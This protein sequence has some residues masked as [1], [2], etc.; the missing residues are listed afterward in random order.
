MGVPRVFFCRVAWNV[1]LCVREELA[2]L[3]GL[4]RFVME[5]RC[6][7]FVIA[8][9]RSLRTTSCVIEDVMPSSMLLGSCLLPVARVGCL[10]RIPVEQIALVVCC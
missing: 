8:P 5:V 9:K 2:G 1:W 6:D 10:G 3:L 4:Y 7:S